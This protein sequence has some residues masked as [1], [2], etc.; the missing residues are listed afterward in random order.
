MKSVFKAAWALMRECCKNYD[1]VSFDDTQ[2]NK[3]RFLVDCVSLYEE[4]VNNHMKKNEKKKVNLDR[5]KVGAIIAIEGSKGHYFTYKNELQSDQLFLGNFSI[6]LIVGLS[7]VEQ[8]FSKDLQVYHL[9]DNIDDVKLYIPEPSS[10]DTLYIDSL[11]RML[12]FAQEYKVNELMQV[13]E[14]ANIFF[15]IEEC[16]LLA[17]SI[18]ISKWIHNKKKK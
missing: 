5:H 1:D 6:P 15:L 14:F 16:T 12:Y 17:N 13:L 4:F 18:D 9:A 7:L 3:N 2:E 11:A 10:C 8:E